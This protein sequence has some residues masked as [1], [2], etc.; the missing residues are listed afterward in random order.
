MNYIIIRLTTGEQILS[1]LDSEEHDYLNISCPMIIKTTPFAYASE[2]HEHVSIVPFCHFTDDKHYK[3]PKSCIMFHKSLH[4][5]LVPHYLN[6]I[7]VYYNKTVLIKPQSKHPE[8]KFRW[9]TDDQEEM[10]I[11]EIK[12][13]IDNIIDFFNSS[14]TE[15]NDSKCIVIEG[16]N[17]IH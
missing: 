3:I 9:N 15:S 16:N 10:T 2:I 7:D 11:D 12:Q 13:T 14:I 5:T 8:N 6:I 4:E 17:T 1:Q